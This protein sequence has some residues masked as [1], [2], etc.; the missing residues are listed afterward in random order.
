[1]PR[2]DKAGETFIGWVEAVTNKA[3]LF[4]GHFWHASEWLPFS[5]VT[6][7]PLPGTDETVVAVSEWMART[8]GISEWKEHGK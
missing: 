8:K 3:I 1:M 4:Q 6:C 2:S 5:Q 7:E